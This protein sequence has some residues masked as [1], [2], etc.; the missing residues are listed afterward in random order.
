MESVAQTAPAS[1]KMLW[2]GRMVSALPALLLLAS[3]SAKLMKA[4]P[5]IQ[6]FAHFGVPA[7]LIMVI[8]I[9]EVGSAMV[10]II[11]CTAVL[12]AILMTGFLGGATFT[13]V[14]VGE[15]WVFPVI[16]GVLVWAGL[17]GRDARVR[18]LLPLRNS[19]QSGTQI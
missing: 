18:A 10:Y 7:N 19:I 3:G 1:K 4:A 11:P 12:G 17:Y 8:G 15:P 9:L 16:A 13:H 6:G 14:R 2:A 5:V